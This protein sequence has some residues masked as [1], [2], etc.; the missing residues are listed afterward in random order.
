[1]RREIRTS[2]DLM[3]CPVVAGANAVEPHAQREMRNLEDGGE[4]PAE[5]QVKQDKRRDCPPE[6]QY[7]EGRQ[8]K[9][10][11]IERL[12]NDELDFFLPVQFQRVISH[13]KD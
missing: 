2:A 4:H 6:R 3:H 7:D 13:P 9:E 5:N 12:A 10:N 11:Q 1:M 8:K